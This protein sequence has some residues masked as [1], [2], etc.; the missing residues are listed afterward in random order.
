MIVV[1]TFKPTSQMRSGSVDAEIQGWSEE[2][3]SSHQLHWTWLSTPIV[4]PLDHT[5][6]NFIIRV[7][8]EVQLG[9]ERT[10]R[11]LLFIPFRSGPQRMSSFSCRVLVRRLGRVSYAKA[12]ALQKSLANTYKTISPSRPVSENSKFMIVILYLSIH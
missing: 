12:L 2:R 5:S 7:I 1:H 3:P 9:V 4:P 11:Q 8:G 10:Y 6:S